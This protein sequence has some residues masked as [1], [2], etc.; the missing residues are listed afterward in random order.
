MLW[1]EDRKSF[2]PLSD[3]EVYFADLIGLQVVTR[4]GVDVG[5]VKDVLDTGATDMLVLDRGGREAM[6]PNVAEFVLEMDLSAGKIVVEP[7]VGLIDGLD[8]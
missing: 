1:Y 6:L 2:P 7:P 3:D 8:D 5:V 4:A